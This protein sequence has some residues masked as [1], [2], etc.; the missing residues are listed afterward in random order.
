MVGK[1]DVTQYFVDKM[2]R[3]VHQVQFRV[4]SRMDRVCD[5]G[6]GARES[7]RA[8]ARRLQRWQQQ[9]QRGRWGQ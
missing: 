8:R 2:S 3:C 7:C 1:G 6:D 9:Q 4:Q 5:G